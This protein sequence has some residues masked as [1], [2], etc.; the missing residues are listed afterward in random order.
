MTSDTGDG[1]DGRTGRR[2][3]RRTAPAIA[4]GVLTAVGV[5]A[6]FWWQGWHMPFTAA[7]LSSK[8]AV[9]VGFFVA[10]GGFAS[11]TVWWQAR[12]GSRSTPPE[13]TD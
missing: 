2:T 7:W 12:R 1:T 9:K 13:K 10:A 4:A 6:I 3:G 8:A 11:V 5:C